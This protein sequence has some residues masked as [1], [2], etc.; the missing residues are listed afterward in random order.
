MAVSAPEKVSGWLFCVQLYPLW[1]HYSMVQWC[2][3]RRR[4]FRRHFLLMLSLLMLL[5]M[6]W[7]VHCTLIFKLCGL[8]SLL[9]GVATQQAWLVRRPYDT[10]ADNFRFLSQHVGSF[11]FFFSLFSCTFSILITTSSMIMTSGCF[12]FMVVFYDWTGS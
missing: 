7:A 8:Q 9:G 4:L 3:T 11:F 6:L 5:L 1:L 12:W 2:R 10:I